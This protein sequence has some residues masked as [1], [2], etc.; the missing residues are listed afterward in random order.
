[1]ARPIHKDIIGGIDPSGTFTFRY[2]LEDAGKSEGEQ[3]GRR[4][5]GV[6]GGTVGGALAVPSVITGAM[7]LGSAPGVAQREGVGAA[8]KHIGRRASDP[9][10]IPWKIHRA[11]RALKRLGTGK[12]T[13]KD[14]ARLRKAVN[15]L[16][17]SKEPKNVLLKTIAHGAAEGA[18]D[19]T[20]DPRNW[21]R[22]GKPVHKLMGKT[23][24]KYLAP[25]ALA[26]GISGAGSYLQHRSGTSLGSKLTPNEREKLLAKKRPKG[27]SNS[28]QPA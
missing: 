19:A 10:T 1:M 27:E 23:L 12:G 7:A 11:R 24:R 8:L 4:A 16:V 17:K 14:T 9:L 20:S 21:E 2:G 25:L 13:E 3:R 28:P 26:G 18:V 22:L 15:T 5:L 6:A